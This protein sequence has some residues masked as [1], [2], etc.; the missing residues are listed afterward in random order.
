MHKIKL[1]NLNCLSTLSD[2]FVFNFRRAFKFESLIERTVETQALHSRENGPM[3]V[4]LFSFYLNQQF[5]ITFNL[6]MFDTM[7]D[8][9]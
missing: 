5:G 1:D 7:F 2:V 8:G 3:A 4:F 9:R 6:D